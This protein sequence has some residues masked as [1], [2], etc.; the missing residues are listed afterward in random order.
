[1]SVK[2]L[3]LLDPREDLELEETYLH[4]WILMDLSGSDVKDELI[5][6][7][8]CIDKETKFLS[9]RERMRTLNDRTLNYWNEMRRF[10]NCE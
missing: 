1:M 6:G 4:T 3:V 7:D 5:A 8:K 10:N 9:K 2:G